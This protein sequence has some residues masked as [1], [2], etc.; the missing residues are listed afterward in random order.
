MQKLNF[1]I[2]TLLFVLFT[3]IGTVSHEY[4]HIAVAKALG[5]STTLHYGYMTWDSS[6]LEE[7]INQ[8]YLD[9]QEAIQ[10]ALPFDEK[11]R[12]EEKQALLNKH[13][14]FVSAGGP[15]QTMLTGII[16]WLLL[17]VGKG[18]RALTG[19]RPID[20]L[21]VF[22]SL[23]WLRELFNLCNSVTMEFIKPDGNF[24]G[25]DE[26][27]IAQFLGIDEGT[28]AIPLAV[29]ALFS[30]SLVV[31]KVLPRKFQ[32]TFI[33]AGLVG[34]LIGFIGWLYILGPIIMP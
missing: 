29:I 28:V 33:L 2:F 34:G 16:G 6:K 5:Y 12:Y 4:G 11:A 3:I 15:L 18:K 26:L 19:F 9:N 23:F 13:S 17:W 25:G 1:F 30:S 27:H 22:L 8:L 31:F 20:W 24:F 7:E 14:L 21:A 32:L 10:Q